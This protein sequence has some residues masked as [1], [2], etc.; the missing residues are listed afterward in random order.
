MSGKIRTENRYAVGTKL[1]G[2]RTQIFGRLHRQNVSATL[3]PK[4]WVGDR[5]QLAC[6]SSKTVPIAMH[7]NFLP[8]VI[9]LGISKL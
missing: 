6:F 8:L 3:K 5:R 7:V 9:L 2:H 1:K 4:L